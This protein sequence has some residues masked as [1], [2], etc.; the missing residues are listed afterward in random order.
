MEVIIISCYWLM[1]FLDFMW[2]YMLKSKDEALNN[3][4]RFKAISE[5]NMRL[6]AIRTDRIGEFTS[7]T[8][9][10]FNDE[11]EVKC[12]LT[13][14]YSTQQN[15]CNRVEEP[16][17]HRNGNIYIKEHGGPVEILGRSTKND[18]IHLEQSSYAQYSRID[19]L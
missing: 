3:F 12:F 15:G 7:T 11:Q 13:A 10:L 2:K 16:N 18:D 19:F 1:I 8:F 6:R 5:S 9:R 4:K 17:N 14:L